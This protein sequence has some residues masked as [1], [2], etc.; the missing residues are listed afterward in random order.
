M[1]SPID[2][3]VTFFN[4]ARSYHAAADELLQTQD[5]RQVYYNDSV[6]RMNYALS[7]ELYLKSF[8][9]D[10][11]LTPIELSKRHYGHDLANILAAC[12]RHGLSLEDSIATRIRRLGALATLTKD[13][14][15]DWDRATVPKTALLGQLP[16]YLESKIGPQ[17]AAKRGYVHDHRGLS[18]GE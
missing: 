15:L 3:A 4:V 11:G 2:K 6:I 18:Q 13:R 14:Y 16:E 17:L 9:I 12:G 1:E 10:K 7:V 8:L 5:G